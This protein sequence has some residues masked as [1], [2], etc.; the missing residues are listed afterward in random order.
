MNENRELKHFL[1]EL[2][3]FFQEN[4]MFHS[5]ESN[6]SFIFEDA[7]NRIRTCLSRLQPKANEPVVALVGMTNVGKSTLLNALFGEDVAPRRN[8]PCTAVPIE[9]KY[10][11]QYRVRIYFNRALNRP[12]WNFQSVEEIHQQLKALAD[13]SGA[14]QSQMIQRPSKLLQ[15]GMVLGDT[16]G[17][18]AAQLGDA[19]G[20]HEA[21]LK[22]YI[23]DNVSRVF[24]V[25]MADQGIGA[26]EVKFYEKFFMPL[27]SDIIVTG[28]ED[29]T[30]KEQKRFR[31]RFLPQLKKPLMR[32]H[33][34]SGKMGVK[35]RQLN[36]PE[37]YA[38]SGVYALKQ[39]FQ[40]ID[41]RK[42]EGNSVAVE[43]DVL[44]DDLAYWLQNDASRHGC[45]LHGWFR[46]DSWFRLQKNAGSNE[47]KEKFLATLKRLQEM[48]P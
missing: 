44:A 39:V 25:V 47:I 36:D 8:G 17:F 34:V 9:F 22:T 45:P 46:P 43:L 16:P 28:S 11:L 18:G 48:Q 42:L 23:Q 31:D 21:A 35:A 3:M 10:A 5:Q 32:F 38:Q 4:K 13:D 37:M 41:P 19:S 1:E 24:W 2:L 30:P 26:T 20:S 7:C 27:C 40:E 15:N 14:E 33:F 12:V 29:W 6:L